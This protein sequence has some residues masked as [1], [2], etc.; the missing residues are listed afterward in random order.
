M[1][2][3]LVVPL[4]IAAISISVLYRDIEHNTITLSLIL[5]RSAGD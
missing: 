1:A 5:V 2:R 4:Q 3:I